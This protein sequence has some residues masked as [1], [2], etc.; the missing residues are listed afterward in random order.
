MID[1]GVDTGPIVKQKYINFEESDDTFTKTYSILR[2]NIELLFLEFLPSLLN[3]T[4]IAKK[5]R[6]T[7]THHNVKDLPKNFSGW[8]SVI[9]EELSKLDN[10]GLIYDTQ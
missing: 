8:N 1:G 6:G 5:Q 3:D 2:D 10:E 9:T 7:G 4:W